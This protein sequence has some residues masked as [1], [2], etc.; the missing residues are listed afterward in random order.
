MCALSR[1]SEGGIVTTVLAMFAS[2]GLAVNDRGQ[3]RVLS[4]LGAASETQVELRAE[5]EFGAVRRLERGPTDPPRRPGRR[6][7]LA[8]TAK[9]SQS[10][11]LSM[12][13]GRSRLIRICRSRSGI[14][15]TI[16][17][18]GS[19]T[20]V[21]LGAGR[22]DMERGA[23]DDVAEVVGAGDGG[24]DDG[25]AERRPFVGPG[26]VDAPR[27]VDGMVAGA[28]R[29]SRRCRSESSAGQLGLAS[30]ARP[31]ASGR[32]APRGS[33]RGSRGRRRA[34]R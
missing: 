15:P 12:K 32:D 3:R 14:P 31:E 10:V 6:R 2:P 25:E 7:L 30:S 23:D 4:A 13:P 29:R 24:R 18:S 19:D 27:Q 22:V 16:C 5:G 11:G 9:R 21:S 20:A 17:G 26:E 33:R 34:S 28:G 8:C 1:I